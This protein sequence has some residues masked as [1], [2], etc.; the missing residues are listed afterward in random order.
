MFGNVVS[1]LSKIDDLA[2][3]WIGGGRDFDQIK[4]ETLSFA[5]S[6]IEPQDAELF[7]S[8]TENDPDFA[9]ANPAVYT[10]L[11]LQIRSISSTAKRECAA[12]PCSIIAI[13]GVSIRKRQATHFSRRLR[14]TATK[15]RINSR[16]EEKL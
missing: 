2:H 8:G 14:F 3:R 10:N 6:V 11:W 7:S 16:A 12:T 13:S 1:E 9:S 5:Q 4:S 15:S